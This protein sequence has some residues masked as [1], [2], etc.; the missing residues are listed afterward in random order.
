MGLFRTKRPGYPGPFP[1]EALRSQ[2]AA[3][4]EALRAGGML[5][6]EDGTGLGSRE[7]RFR[8]IHQDEALRFVRSEA[9][10]PKQTGDNE[11]LRSGTRLNW[12]AGKRERFGLEGWQ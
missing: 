6:N 4:K 2:K 12:P 7:K 10:Q 5:A 9:L 1:R 11:A 8:R 3:G